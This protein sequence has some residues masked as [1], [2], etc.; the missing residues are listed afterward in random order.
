MTTLVFSRLIGEYEREI[1]QKVVKKWLYK[2]H[3]S[4]N[5]TQYYAYIISTI[6]TIAYNMCFPREDSVYQILMHLDHTLMLT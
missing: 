5:I 4:N 1:C 2:Y 6:L 3:F